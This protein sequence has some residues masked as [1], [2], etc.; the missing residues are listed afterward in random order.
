V[1]CPTFGGGPGGKLPNEVQSWVTWPGIADA[2][3]TN[4]IAA[5]SAVMTTTRHRFIEALLSRRSGSPD[6]EASPTH[7]LAY[8][9]GGT[10][11]QSLP[12]ATQ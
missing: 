1:V 5:I 12:L 11:G 10:I 7:R 9:T 6:K 8:P 3:D 4:A 2:G